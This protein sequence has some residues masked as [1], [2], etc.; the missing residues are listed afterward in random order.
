MQEKKRNPR[1]TAMMLDLL[2]ILVGVL[3]VICTVLVFLNPES[4]QILF[5]VIFGLAAL[6]GGVNGWFKLQDSKY[7]K[8]KRPGG[9][10][11]CVMAFVLLAAGIISAV[12]IWR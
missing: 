11:Q 4:N 7:D 1:N 6:L 8:K 3:V 9:I 12:S 5:P 2:H 10:A